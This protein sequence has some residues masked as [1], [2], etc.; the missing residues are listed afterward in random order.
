[1]SII[2]SVILYLIPA[3][4]S[5][6]LAVYGWRRR[7]ADGAEQLSLLMFAVAFWSICHTLSIASSTLA[8]ALFCQSYYTGDSPDEVAIRAYA[9]SLYRRAEWTWIQ[10]RFPLVNHRWKPEDGFSISDWK[11]Y[12]ESMILYVLALASPTFPRFH[13]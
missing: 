5:A 3:A 1:M 12:D 9:D 13:T 10:P 8:G 4:T 11:G 6:V 7:G 2:P